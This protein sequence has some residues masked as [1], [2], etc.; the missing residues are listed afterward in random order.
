MVKEEEPEAPHHPLIEELSLLETS[1]TSPEQQESVESLPL[2]AYR[3]GELDDEEASAL[4]RRLVHDDDARARLVTVAGESLPTPSPFLRA[5]VL[6]AFQEMRAGGPNKESRTSKREASSAKRR[7]WAPLLVAAILVLSLGGIFLRDD[8]GGPLPADLAYQISVRGLAEIRSQEAVVAEAV[9]AYAET[10]LE[11]VIAPSGIAAG[12]VD[13]AVYRHEESS[14]LRVATSAQA[15]VESGSAVFRQPARELLGD[16]PG[17]Y[18][19]LVAVA[20]PGRLDE[21]I[22]SAELENPGDRYRFYRLT[23]T[24]LP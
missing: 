10:P 9:E 13:F 24:L 15:V 12:D 1:G 8:G 16:V 22:S 21:R 18:E 3:R 17:D 14:W 7:H 5:R 2:E 4:E 20:R 23:V 19:L 6:R 11:L